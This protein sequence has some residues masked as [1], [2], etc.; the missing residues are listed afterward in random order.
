MTDAELFDIST[1]SSTNA[2]IAYLYYDSTSRHW[3]RNYV[4][5]SV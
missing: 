1:F 5:Y 3:H 2:C 4:H